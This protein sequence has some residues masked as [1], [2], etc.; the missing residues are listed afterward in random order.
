MVLPP[1]TAPRLQVVPLATSSA[2]LGSLIFAALGPEK[3]PA[4]V[5]LELCLV[6][7]VLIFGTT[8]HV[9]A[10]VFATIPVL[11]GYPGGMY[12]LLFGWKHENTMREGSALL[13]F[14][15]GSSIYPF[16]ARG[17]VRGS[18]QGVC[19][20]PRERESCQ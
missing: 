10:G 15:R 5:G 2:I 4:F 14:P 1:G 9:F 19:A 12:V 3:G 11:G 8:V 6:M 17:E 20:R 7:V 16:E 18:R 13:S